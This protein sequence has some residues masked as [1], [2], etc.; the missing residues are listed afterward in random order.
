ME[1]MTMKRTIGKRICSIILT[2]AMALSLWSA[3]SPQA[4]SVAM[5]KEESEDEDEIPE[6]G[7]T[8]IYTLDDLAM[9]RSNLKGKFILMN[10]IDMSEATKP[11]GSIDTGN[12]WVPIDGF[13]GEL[14]GNGYCIKGMHIYGT[15]NLK[16]LAFLSDCGGHIYNLGMKEVD[17]NIQLDKESEIEDIAAIM[18]AGNQ[19]ILENCYASGSIVVNTQRKRCHVSGLVSSDSGIDIFN[20]Y[21]GVDINA[22]YESNGEKEY[23]SGY[24]ITNQCWRIS[25]CYNIAKINNGEGYAIGR[26]WYPSA[27]KVTDCF[28]LKGTASSDSEGTPLT[29]SQMKNKNYFT[30]FDFDTVWDMDPYHNYPYPQLRSCPQERV[31][32]MTILQQPDQVVYNQ[33]DKISLSGGRVKIVYEDGFEAEVAMDESM[34]GNHDMMKLGTQS[35]CLTKSGASAAFNIIVNEIPVSSITLGKKGY[36]E[37]SSAN[38]LVSNLVMEKG[39]KEELMASILPENASN[40]DVEWSSS[41]DNI[42]TVDQNGVVRAIALGQATVTAKATNGVEA[43]CEVSVIIPCTSFKITNKGS[44]K[45]SEGGY[46]TEVNV[47]SSFQYKYE[48]YPVGATE[49]VQW[50]SDNSTIATVDANGNVTGVKA[51]TTRIVAT[52]QSGKKDFAYVSVKNVPTK[53]ITVG[54][55]KIKSIKASKKKLT[56]NWAKVKNADYYQV[57]IATN[58]SFSKGK[59]S[60]EIVGSKCV[61]KGKK[62]KTYYI[63]VRGIYEPESDGKDI[64]GKWSAVKKKKTK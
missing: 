3:Y 42:V 61:F 58:K 36:D 22:I 45:S 56:I 9:I 48:M 57:Q 51:G 27:W 11:G 17:I 28:Y 12:G 60:Y 62:K 63:R 54:R 31:K 8:P 14:N 16:E 2:L 41:D 43:K 46:V 44:Y 7:Y 23:F 38:S 34:L 50:S 40:K 59:K 53:K 47:G 29:D 13:E 5:I 10:D 32:E 52:T 33:G 39:D 55:G 6:E 4:V 24:G 21:N 35:I 15:P 64:Y 26:T 19:G 49:K 18:T 30:N 1:E 37:D 20:C 25:N